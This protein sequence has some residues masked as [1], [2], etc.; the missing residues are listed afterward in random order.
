MYY[1]CAYLCTWVAMYVC[2]SVGIGVC[3]VKFSSHDI[4]NITKKRKLSPRH[5]ITVGLG[6]V[7]TRCM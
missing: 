2:V 6:A 7:L 1:V 4:Y 5:L 3:E